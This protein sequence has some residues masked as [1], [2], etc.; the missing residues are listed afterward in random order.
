MRL[1]PYIHKAD[2]ES[3]KDWITDERTHAMWCANHMKYPLEKNDFER[4]LT[5]FFIKVGDC[6]FTAV[7]DDGKAIGFVCCSVDFGSN[8]AML[9]FVMIDPSE[10]GK[11]YGK[12]MI[13]LAVKY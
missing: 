2:F 6:P 1:R 3:I 11:G 4:N 5:D 7:T 12:E 10:R 8:E 9:A 13:R